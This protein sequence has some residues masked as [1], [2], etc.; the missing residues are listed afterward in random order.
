MI[1]FCVLNY[2]FPGHSVCHFVTGVL[3]CDSISCQCRRSAPRENM[4]EP[5]TT[6]PYIS[7]CPSADFGDVITHMLKLQVSN[8]FPEI[9]NEKDSLKTGFDDNFCTMVFFVL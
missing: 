4:N 8:I 6:L 5:M 7:S 3:G 1:D 9:E 2:T